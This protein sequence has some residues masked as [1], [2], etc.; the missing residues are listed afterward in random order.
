MGIARK[1]VSARVPE[2]SRYLQSRKKEEEAGT[3][4]QRG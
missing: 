1:F 2:L 3:R 4:Q